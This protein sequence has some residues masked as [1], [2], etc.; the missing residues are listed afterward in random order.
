MLHRGGDPLVAKYDPDPTPH[1]KAW[2]HS[3]LTHLQQTL[4]YRALAPGSPAAFMKMKIDQ[5]VTDILAWCNNLNNREI[6][7]TWNTE[8]DVWECNNCALRISNWHG[9]MRSSH[10]VLL[11]GQVG[12]KMSLE[13]WT[14]LKAMIEGTDGHYR[15]F[16]VMHRD[17][18]PGVM[19][20]IDNNIKFYKGVISLVKSMNFKDLRAIVV[21]D[22]NRCLGCGQQV[23]HLREHVIE[24]HL[25]DIGFEI[26]KPK[27]RPRPPSVKYRSYTRGRN[28][29]SALS[30]IWNSS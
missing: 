27:E 18:R 2:D 10:P 30:D 29:G 9:H 16:A 24:A 17:Y 14:L 13:E 21:G 25:D 23:N 4:H 22:D 15:L 20:V 28:S 26:I 1:I 12:F 7:Y 11:W 8:K 3:H 5:L 6:F 19:E